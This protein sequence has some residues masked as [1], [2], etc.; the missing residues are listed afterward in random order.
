[1]VKYAKRVFISVLLKTW[2]RTAC[3]HT[4]AQEDSEPTQGLPLQTGER[5]LRGVRACVHRGPEP[6]GYVETMGTKCLGLCP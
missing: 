4:G 1:M 2:L 5:N 6:E 3:V